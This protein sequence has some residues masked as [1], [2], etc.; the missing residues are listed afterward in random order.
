MDVRKA[1]LRR[2]NRRD[3]FAVLVIGVT[4]AFL[5][6][7]TLVVVAATTGTTDVARKFD[8]EG[9]V[10]DAAS[11]DEARANAPDGAM[12]LPLS[13]VTDSTGTERYVVGIP[14]DARDRV[15]E[16]EIDLPLPDEGMRRGTATEPHDVRLTGPQSTET[17]RV[18]P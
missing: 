18:R 14:S 11:L 16:T 12:I 2:W 6:G 3:V 15:N 1:I 8:S 13:R 10:T 7:T 17:V 4:I 5:T 9:A